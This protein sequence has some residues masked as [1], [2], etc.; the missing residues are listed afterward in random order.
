M[1]K[2]VAGEAGRFGR[3]PRVGREAGQEAV[4]G[5]AVPVNREKGE[6]PLVGEEG[7]LGAVQATGKVFLGRG[8]VLAQPGFEGETAG[9][10]EVGISK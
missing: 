3:N 2:P 1:L 9:G 10:L 6:C 8:G 5:G 7:Q 4:V